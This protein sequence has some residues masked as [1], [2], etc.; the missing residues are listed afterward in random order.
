MCNRVLIIDDKLGPGLQVV[1]EEFP[2]LQVE[3]A[4]R[5]REGAQRGK[6]GEYDAIILD[7][8]LPDVDGFEVVADIRSVGCDT[9]ILII[10]G[11]KFPLAAC[12]AAGAN[13][14]LEKPFDLDG[15]LSQ[16]RC[17]AQNVIPAAA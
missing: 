15:L 10:S 11:R 13:G 3:I 9:P 14:Y 17:M 16:I 8:G 1:L 4:T 12:V 6:S 7:M 2:D 5:G